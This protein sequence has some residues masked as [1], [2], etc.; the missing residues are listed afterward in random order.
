MVKQLNYFRTEYSEGK[1][2]FINDIVYRVY[3]KYFQNPELTE[4]FDKIINYQVCP[5]FSGEKKKIFE[6]YY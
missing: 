6:Y 3:N 4:G 1:D 5:K 2:K